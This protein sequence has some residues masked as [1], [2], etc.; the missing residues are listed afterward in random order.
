MKSSTWCV[1]I[2]SPEN[3]LL[4]SKQGNSLHQLFHFFKTI[5][6]NDSDQ[7]YFLVCQNIK[8]SLD[9]IDV[10]SLDYV[11]HVTLRNCDLKYLPNFRKAERFSMS[12]CSVAS[13]ENFSKTYTGSCQSTTFHEMYKLRYYIS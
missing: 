4:K 3:Y 7:E 11:K 9:V 12:C 6:S 13:Y 2:K 8:E 5:K 10:F 1:F